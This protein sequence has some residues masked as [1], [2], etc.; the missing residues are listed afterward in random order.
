MKILDPE[1]MLLVSHFL[2]HLMKISVVTM[3]TLNADMY[4][5][6]TTRWYIYVC[7]SVYV[8]F[9]LHDVSLCFYK[10]VG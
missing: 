7:V 10:G 9:S 5:Q 1:V 2:L 3:F 8:Y 6:T 4:S